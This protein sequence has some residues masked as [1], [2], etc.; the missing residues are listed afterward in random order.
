VDWTSVR[1]SAG[2]T[3]GVNDT[4]EYLRKK[5]NGE[6]K[7]EGEYKPKGGFHDVPVQQWYV[8]SPIY[9]VE[10]ESFGRPC[11]P[12]QAHTH[13]ITPTGIAV[14]IGNSLL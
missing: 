6:I 2:G 7:E 4:L 13:A 11:H 12:L 9:V 14:V 10:V 8:L 5:R 1:A 3:E